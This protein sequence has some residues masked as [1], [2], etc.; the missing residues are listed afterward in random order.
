MSVKAISGSLFADFAL[1]FVISQ[2]KHWPTSFPGLGSLG[3]GNFINS[4]KIKY[5]DNQW[6]NNILHQYW[7]INI[8]CHIRKKKQLL[9][10]LF[11]LKQDYPGINLDQQAFPLAIPQV[12]PV[13]HL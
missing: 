9:L 12:C 7:S 6:F 13:I 2:P 8:F 4:L 1:C 11:Y 5:F 10:F 3:Q